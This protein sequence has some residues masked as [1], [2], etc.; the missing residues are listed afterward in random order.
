MDVIATSTKEKFD[1]PN[2]EDKEN[3]EN[4]EEDAVE[5]IKAEEELNSV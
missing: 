2:K 5:M 4:K 3:K 1:S